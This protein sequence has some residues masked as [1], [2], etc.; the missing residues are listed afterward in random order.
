MT[1]IPENDDDELLVYGEVGTP[2][3]PV[4]PPPARPAAGRIIALALGIAALAAGGFFALQAGGS[5]GGAD[6]P[7]AAVQAMLDAVE[8]EDALGVLEALTPGERDVA[9][10][11]LTDVI[12]ELKRLGVL[13]DDLDLAAVKGIDFS[14]EDVEMKTE[15][16][17]DDLA[18]VTITG[19]SVRARTTPAEAPIG[20]LLKDLGVDV[21]EMTP[22]V[23]T[24]DASTD[25]EVIA[26][27][28]RG[29]GWY[30]SLGYSMAEQGRREAG[31][32]LPSKGDAVDPHG[33]S[34]PEAAVQAL[35]EAI[36]DMD[37]ERIIA[38][39]PPGEMSALHDYAPIFLE[40]AEKGVAEAR[41]QGWELDV[42]KLELDEF[43][44]AGSVARV[45][46]TEIAGSATS[47]AM[48]VTFDIDS[49][50]AEIEM[51]PP[52]ET[53]MSQRVCVDDL[54]EQTGMPFD[55]LQGD[56]MPRFGFTVVE[57]DSEWYI[58]PIRSMFDPLIDVLQA[59][60]PK[61]LREA[62]EQVQSFFV[63]MSE[64]FSSTGGP[65]EMGGFDS[66]APAIPAP[67]PGGEEMQRMMCE[68]LRADEQFD[69]A[70]LPE[71]CKQ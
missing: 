25:G 7:E 3:A 31:A 55:F 11:V 38:L 5:E 69:E 13:A 12:D 66:P 4:A 23:T 65:V 32:P 27:I 30:V 29:G 60:E 59:F 51:G 2:A 61:G 16:L 43:E 44:R 48:Q 8:Q 26:T 53:P 50:C 64:G 28:K 36:Q 14:F 17:R 49:K 1:D 19:G 20:K 67:P 21:S 56:K 9:T 70:H 24:E 39:T 57:V 52:G 63:G 34:S 37:L 42:S 22:T 62:I 18:G 46:I 58:S 40:D 33:A 35:V 47:D 6:S 68:S 15:D 71:F 45:A 54:A 10:D 41:R